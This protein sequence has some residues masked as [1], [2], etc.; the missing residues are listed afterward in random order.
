MSEQTSETLTFLF[1]DVEKS[2][3]LL[4]QLGSRYP[5]AMGRQQELLRAAFGAQ[6]GVEVDTQ[7]DSF[8]VAFARPRDAVLAAVAAQASLGSEGWPDGAD[9]RVR[10]GIHTGPVELAG[11]RY[12]GLAVHRA[13]RIC[14][15]G[16]GGQ[17]LLSE[18]TRALLEDDEHDL[19]E[20]GLR[21]LGSHH[22]KDFHRPVRL[23]QVV[24]APLGEDFPALRTP[25][26][27]TL[28]LD[29]HASTARA[30]D[31]ERD[32]TVSA[33]REHAA[34][35]RLTLEEFSER[36]ERAYAARTTGELERLAADLPAS[37]DERVRPRPKRFTAAVLG[38]TQ[39][40]G[41]WRLPRRSGGLVL[42]GDADLDLR[43]A[44][45]EGS[46]ASINVWVLFGNVDL[47]VPEGVEVDLGGVSIFG[48]RR[49]WGRDVPPLPGTPLV[50]VRIFSL[51]GTA[52]LWRVPAAWIG[53]SFGQVIKALRSD[54]KRELPPGPQP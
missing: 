16:H 5:H 24:A 11:D 45:L 37:P 35:G 43:Q 44:E 40:T 28:A 18:A 21:D 34:T 31:E 20:I 54:A 36:T 47:Y 7:G 41:R 6:R 22:L 13:A 10:M 46:V 9:V 52:D 25:G 15:A 2:T 53:R 23:F 33:L 29:R 32:E 4:R 17:V 51:F 49:E 39:R 30:S 19:A 26:Q 50:R 12:V 1:T 42:L 38:N 3:D 8:F 14:A 27:A 48:H